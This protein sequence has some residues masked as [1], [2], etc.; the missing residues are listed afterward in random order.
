MKGRINIGI[1]KVSKND[2][3]KLQRDINKEVKAVHPDFKGLSQP[4]LIHILV[5]PTMREG[6]RVD[7][8]KIYGFLKRRI[9]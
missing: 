5:S 4:G 9:K 3:E 7:P 2:L 6:F 8:D 1:W